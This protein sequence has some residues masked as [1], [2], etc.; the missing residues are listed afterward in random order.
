M[1]LIPQLIIVRESGGGN[2]TLHGAH[3]DIHLSRVQGERF[4]RPVAKR[5][6][7]QRLGEDC[8]ESSLTFWHACA[9]KA[10]AA[11]LIVQLNALAYQPC[12]VTFKEYTGLRCVVKS[13]EIERSVACRGTIITGTTAATWRVEGKIVL[14]HAPA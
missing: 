11:A 10:A 3:G 9:D 13:Y 8:P 12:K 4:R 14:E 1:A 6:G 2:L 5:A 7:Y